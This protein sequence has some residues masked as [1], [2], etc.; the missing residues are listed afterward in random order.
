MTCKRFM[1][2][3]LLCAIPHLH[4]QNCTFNFP[5]ARLLLESQS[6]EDQSKE[7][8]DA[9]LKALNELYN[10]K[11]L[12][13]LKTNLEERR[14]YFNTLVKDGELI[15]DGEL[16]D[17]VKSLLD[18]ILVNMQLGPRTLFLVRDESANA[19]NMGDNNIFVHLGLIL[20]AE[21]EAQ[22]VFVLG[23]E[24]GHNELNHYQEKLL[25]YAELATNDSIQRRIQKIKASEY[26]RVSAMNS[27]MIP[28]ILENRSKSRLAEEA[29]DKYGYECLIAC[30]YDPRK[31]YPIFDIFDL[32][33]KVYDTAKLNLTELLFLKETGLDFTRPLTFRTESSL[34]SFETTPDTLEDLLRT[35]PFGKE[36]QQVFEQQIDAARLGAEAPDDAGTFPYY[37]SLAEREIIMDGLYHQRLDQALFYALYLYRREPE[38]CFARMVIPFCFAYLG[39]EKLKR[40][41]GSHLDTQSP[42]FDQNYNEM[43][44]FLREISPDQCFAIASNW[45]KHF[46]DYLGTEIANPTLL[47]LDA[48]DKNYDNFNI[49]Y[50]TELNRADTYY[51]KPIFE[52]IKSE[53]Q[54]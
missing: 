15:I 30:G 14:E 44:H 3:V 24:L 51:L 29:S 21:N 12:S 1:L 17:Y 4:G 13:T 23:H 26:G 8:Y 45:T 5:H 27:L 9:E 43:L 52:L 20:R 36:R 18:K 50:Q 16:Y 33:E 11:K 22:V 31:A 28:W 2:L 10:G 49:R 38:N 46:K 39:Y 35:H 47:I 32:A 41:S 37:K 48:K 42:Y 53:T 7:A 54:Q 19:F 6:L 34:G 25:D 40:R